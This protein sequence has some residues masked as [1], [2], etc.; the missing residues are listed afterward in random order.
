MKSKYSIHCINPFRVIDT[1]QSMKGGGLGSKYLLLLHLFTYY[2][3]QSPSWEAN[4]LSAS[5]ETPHSLWNPK[6]HCRI[7][8]CP[9][10]VSVFS[11]S[12][13]SMPPHPTWR[14]VSILTFRLRLGLP[15]GLIP[16]GVPFMS[17]PSHSSRYDHPNNIGW[18]VQNI[19]LLIM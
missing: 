11:S 6:V 15:N 17:R 16:S 3:E 4:R 18:A 8:K 14:S 12:I 9:P 2:I 5:Q 19:K 13:Q 7:H 1:M 10:P